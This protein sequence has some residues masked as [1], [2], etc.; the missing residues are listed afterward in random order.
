MN[1]PLTHYISWRAAAGIV[2]ATCATA[3]FAQ[4]PTDGTAN[5]AT[6]PPASA[7]T[8]TT[9]HPHDHGTLK[10]ADRSFVEKAAESGREEVEVARIAVERSTNADVKKFAQMMVDDHSKANEELASIAAAKNLKLKDKDKNENKWEKKDLKDF[11]RDFVK[12][13]VSDH[14]KDVDLFSKE[15]KNGGDAELVE[16]ARKTLPTINKHLE[17]ASELEKTVK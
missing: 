10:H 11:D 8:E 7:T 17:A 12:K 6:R 14:K 3:L 5:T 15:S 13:M 16:F 4:T 1:K 9:E 2:A